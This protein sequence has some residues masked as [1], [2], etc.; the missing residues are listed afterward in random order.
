MITATN[1]KWNKINKYRIIYAAY[2]PI[3]HYVGL[4][5]DLFRLSFYASLIV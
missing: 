2:R 5:S 4:R 3:V 1:E